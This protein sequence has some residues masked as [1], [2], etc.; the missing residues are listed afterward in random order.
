MKSPSKKSQSMKTYS[1]RRESTHYVGMFHRDYWRGRRDGKR[2]PVAWQSALGA[3]EADELCY[4]DETRNSVQQMISVAKTNLAHL[5][6]LLGAN[7]Q[8]AEALKAEN[9]LLPEAVA[10]SEYWTSKKENFFATFLL[11]CE[12]TALT[13][14][15]KTTFGQ[16]LIPALVVAVLLSALVA[17]GIKLLLGKVS[18]EKKS[19]V[20]WVVLVIALLLTVLGLVGFVI[21]RAETFKSGLVGGGPD[22][23]QINLGNIFLMIGLTLGVP[24][25][26]G[27]LYEA[28]QERMK[29]AGN[30]LRLYKERS[31]L[32][33]LNNKWNVLLHKLE[34]FDARIDAVTSQ[35]IQLRKNKYI[36]GYHIG[37]AKNP[38]AASHFEKLKMQTA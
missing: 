3:V 38:E 32:M 9:G 34:E 37:G 33:E 28:A 1:A 26:C 21:L 29:T 13:Y 22:I 35:T 11:F 23:E 4:R 18:P 19:Q 30:S 17:F 6:K 20:K 8:K 5:D 7:Q 36:R 2:A 24:F 15:A 14:I 31:Q 10:Q 27:V 25:I 12:M 16:G